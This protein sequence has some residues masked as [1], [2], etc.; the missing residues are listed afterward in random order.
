MQK[1]TIAAATIALGALFASDLA[2][3]EVNYGPAKQGNQCFTYAHTFGRDGRFGSWGACP[4]PA[5]AAVAPAPK[6]KTNGSASR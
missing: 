4:K 3:A 5:A 1:L 6:S 2:L